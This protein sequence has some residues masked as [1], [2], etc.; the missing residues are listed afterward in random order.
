MSGNRSRNK[1]K[2]AE[3]EQLEYWDEQNKKEDQQWIARRGCEFGKRDENP[4][5]VVQGV[6][7]GK[8][9]KLMAEVKRPKE[10]PKKLTNAMSQVKDVSK[11]LDTCMVVMREDKRGKRD[12]CQGEWYAYLKLDDLMEL[13]S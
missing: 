9:I 7:R 10:L 11:P 3:K 2:L 12:G 4:D 1:G 5:I 6:V 13:I 8:K